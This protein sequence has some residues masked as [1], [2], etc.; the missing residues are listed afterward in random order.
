MF[1]DRVEFVEL[2][3]CWFENEA[4]CW[5]SVGP[6]H[7]MPLNRKKIVKSTIAIMAKRTPNPTA[8]TGNERRYQGSGIHILLR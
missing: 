4:V 2:K 3:E 8:N 1:E 5:G 7:A 6:A